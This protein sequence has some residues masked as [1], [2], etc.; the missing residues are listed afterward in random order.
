[1]YIL[2]QETPQGRQYVK[3]WTYLLTPHAT[4]FTFARDEAYLFLTARVMNR[5]MGANK[6]LQFEFVNQE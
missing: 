1:M 4:S 3:E 5:L 2:F 6:N